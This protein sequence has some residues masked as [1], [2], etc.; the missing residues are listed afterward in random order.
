MFSHAF[1]STSISPSFSDSTSIVKSEFAVRH[2]I[3]KFKQFLDRLCQ[4]SKLVQPIVWVED[5]HSCHQEFAAELLTHFVET[6]L[7]LAHPIIIT[8]SEYNSKDLDRLRNGMCSL[9]LFSG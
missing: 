6:G 8:T 3:H 2:S 1:K 5:I 9:S 7:C 4:N